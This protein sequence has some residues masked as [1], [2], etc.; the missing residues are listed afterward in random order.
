MLPSQSPSPLKAD[1][2]APEDA[3]DPLYVEL[4]NVLLGGSSNENDPTV[5]RPPLPVSFDEY[6]IRARDDGGI[7][8]FTDGGMNTNV[9]Y[10]NGTVFSDDLLIEG[11]YYSFV[12]QMLYA[13]LCRVQAGRPL[14]P[15][16]VY[17]ETQTPNPFYENI[18]LAISRFGAGSSRIKRGG[19]TF[20]ARRGV[21]IISQDELGLRLR[22][23]GVMEL[24]D[25]TRFKEIHNAALRSFF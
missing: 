25:K 22:E 24:F 2:A 14:V 17:V 1:D 18:L 12:K 4:L 13:A 20:M 3:R 16:V 5:S 19:L 6:T 9:I 21:I 7:E 8:F 23:D 15:D 10:S 11:R